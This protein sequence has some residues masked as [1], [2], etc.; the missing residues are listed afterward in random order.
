VETNGSRAPRTLWAYAYEIIPSQASDHMTAIQ[1]LL[2]EE[3][4]RARSTARTWTGQLIW[5]ERVTHILVVSDTPDQGREVNR[6]LQDRLDQMKTGFALTLPMP[7]S[8]VSGEQHPA[9][10]A[11]RPRSPGTH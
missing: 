8:P 9:P 10:E 3:Q 5:E 6:R 1:A 7:V 4:S 11:R 2:K